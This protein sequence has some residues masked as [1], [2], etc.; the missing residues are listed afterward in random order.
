MSARRA[1]T[2]PWTVD[3]TPTESFCIRDAKGQALA[4]VYYED[5]TCRRMAIGRLTR[6]EAWRIAANCAFIWLAGRAKSSDSR[7]GGK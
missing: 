1:F 4:F 5:E 7:P 2:A 3:D 6:D